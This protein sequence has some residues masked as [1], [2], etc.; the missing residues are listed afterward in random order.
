MLFRYFAIASLLAYPQTTN[1]HGVEV[2]QCITPDGDLRFFVEHWHDDLAKTIDAGS[3]EIRQSEDG[4][5][6]VTLTKYPDA[7]I[8]N[9][10]I[11]N[12]T[13]PTTQI[14]WGCRDDTLPEVVTTCR[15]DDKVINHR[16]NTDWVYFERPAT[17]NVPI[18][19]TLLSGNTVVLKDGCDKQGVEVNEEGFDVNLYPA[20]VGPATY[21]DVSAPVPKVNGYNLPQTL[22]FSVKNPGAKA[23]VTYAISATD[24][25]DPNPSVVADTPSGTEFAVGTHTV[26]VTA[27]D[28]ENNIGQGVLTIVVEGP[29][30]APS[31]SPTS[32]PTGNPSSSPSRSPSASPVVSTND[33]SKSPTSSPSTSPTVSPTKAPSAAPTTLGPSTS[34]TR[35]PSMSPTVS[36][37]KAPS[38]TLGPSTSPTRAP[39]MSPTV[40]PTK[41][42]STSPTPAPTDGPSTS[43]T[44]SPS[45]SP[46]VSPTNGP[47]KSPTPAPTG[48]P[49]E[50]PTSLPSMQPS[51]VEQSIVITGSFSINRDVCSFSTEQRVAYVD[52]ILLSMQEVTNCDDPATCTAVI[53]NFCGSTY[54][55]RRSLEEVS[56]RNLQSADW[57]LDYEITQTFTCEYASC[58][59]S[60]DSS[61]TE[62]FIASIKAP[63]EASLASDQF[64]TVLSTKIQASGAFSADIVACFAVWGVVNEAALEVEPPSDV[65]A[66]GLFYPDWES[67]SGTCL[68]GDAPTYMD[69]NPGAWLYD[70]LDACCE[71]YFGGWNKN[72]C[73]NIKGS[74]L[75]YVS[76]R[77]EKCVTDCDE[78]QGGR[79]GGL[80]NPI[81]DDLFTDP[82]TCCEKELGWKFTD[83]CEMESLGSS[84]YAGTGKYYRGDLAGVEVCVKDCVLNTNDP[85][86]GGLIEDSYVVQHDTP[87]ECCTQEYNWMTN[88]LCTARTTHT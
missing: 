79:C 51:I 35:A 48:S 25:C 78:S 14:G 18:T 72:K 57:Q 85:V 88:E 65:D 66:T 29:T 22:T 16:D 43:P 33:P 44:L 8:N 77:L 86:C 21:L 27:T 36:P 80:A 23:Y 41:A 28:N 61:T 75:W 70:T 42:P 56:S 54:N 87:E 47:S 7:F 31:K 39:S 20:V 30:Y 71:R 83:F 69:L 82:R 59:S 62:A 26:P 6:D 53:T 37:T 50:S 60:S 12:T 84:C 38:T 73:L 19:Y 45:K 81:S 63:I 55:S 5:D 46:T 1:G 17:C 76:H 74:G 64:L 40:S 32:S 3:M 15:N 34:P 2:R 24:D 13:D 4:Q 10:D 52:S 11:Y 67:D 68:Q 9:K 49:T 58:N